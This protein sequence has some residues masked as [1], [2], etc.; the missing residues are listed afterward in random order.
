MHLQ[1]NES[2]PVIPSR[3]VVIFPGNTAPVRVGR[4]KSKAAIEQA[5]AGKK[6]VVLLSQKDVHQEDEPKAD[7]LHRVGTLCRIER[8]VGT[9]ETGYQAVLRGMCRIEVDLF[10]T[11]ANVLAVKVSEVP[12]R[13]DVD[14]QTANALIESMKKLAFEILELIP[15]DTRQVVQLVDAITEL[16]VLVNLAAENLQVASAKKQQ[17]LEHVS[18]KARALDL[19]QLMQSQKESL[20]LQAEIREKLSHKMGKQQ[21]ESILREQL[22][23]IRDELG[24]GAEETETDFTKKIDDAGMPD[25]VR[26]I[27]LTEARRLESL[28]ANSP[29]SNVIRNYL[30]LLCAMP[31]NTSSEDR[32]DLNNARKILDADHYGLE[33][34]KRRIIQHLA[35]MKLKK[36][37]KGSILLLV[38]P[39]GVGKTS[40][41]QSIAKALDRKFVRA[42]LGGVR[43]DSEIRGHR[44]TYIG[45]MP[46]RVIQG[47]KRAGVNNP[48]F[49]LD[50]IDKLGRGYSGDPAAALLEVL[51]PEQNNT[52]ADHYLDVPFD[53]S[54][55]LFIATANSLE[56]IP[57]PL[58]DRME[59]IEVAGYTTPEKLH[60]A[61]N[62]LVP[63]QFSEHGLTPEQ[64]TFSDDALLRLITGYTR[65]AG[66]RELQR[67]VTALCRAA[68]ERVLD[69]KE[70]LPVQIGSAQ[71]ED[72]LGAEKFIYEV[73]ERV[74]PPGV[75]TGL[76][77]T[78]RGGEILF[79]ESSLMPGTGKLLL[80]GQLGEVMKESAH[81]ALS[82]VRSNLPTLV[83]GFDYDKKDIHVH[84]PAGA[85][86]KDGPSAGVTMLTT[87]A[88]LF[89]GRAV[90]PKLAMTGEITLRGAVTPVGGVKEKVLGAHRAGIERILLSRRNERDL[91]DV[92]DEVKSQIQFLFVDTVAD[93]LKAALDLDV[94]PAVPLGAGGGA[95][96]AGVNFGDSQTV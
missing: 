54:K 30:D 62:H 83:P 10:E 51:D 20:E 7:D 79:V 34:I 71:V 26:K 32:I 94:T 8:V 27:A 9:P 14:Q 13:L 4:A 53:L 40:L 73:A 85:I 72:I 52:F 90:S 11:K 43:D 5:Q 86:P 1:G 77:W 88:S 89:S 17:L 55:V 64:A 58:L 87:L 81:I 60:I 45:A 6:F 25:D 3:N 21:R 23:A 33:K 50:E 47:I 92:P 84:V 70:A 75:V 93:V 29:E 49:M 78:P 42:S 24:E 18:L 36:E 96:A 22:K 74:V 19:L 2:I 38:G 82:L 63:K 61:K 57:G 68:T 41:R 66:V 69:E 46:G 91:K 37:G 80:T 39:P 28:G 56:S 12:E 65:E 44:R 59:V 48:V 35:V 15:G 76:A 31:W 16:P 95:S 67:H